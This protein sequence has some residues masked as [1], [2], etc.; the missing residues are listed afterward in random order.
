MQNVLTIPAVY[1][2]DKYYLLVQKRGL[3]ETYKLHVTALTEAETRVYGAYIFEVK[4]NFFCIISQ[5]AGALTD[6]AESIALTMKKTIFNA[7]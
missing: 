5:P 2:D 6:L 4:N 1:N 7:L 3:N